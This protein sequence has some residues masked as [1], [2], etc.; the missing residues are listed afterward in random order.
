MQLRQELYDSDLL[1]LLDEPSA[2]LDFEATMAL[3]NM[4]LSWRS[5]GKTIIAAE[6]RIAYLWDLIDRAV[7]MENG[8]ISRQ[9]TRDELFVL[10]PEELAQMGLRTN[11]MEAPE[12]SMLPVYQENDEPMILHDFNFS[13]RGRKQRLAIACALASGREILLLDEP[14]SG[15]DHGHMKE[16]ADLLKKLRDMGR[17]FL[18][19]HMTRN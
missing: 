9:F 17:P 6:H 18:S 4:I 5:K 7:I 11:I 16:T 3:R 10:T 13:Y 14:T 19:L 15:L 2:N 8:R 12:K 1:L